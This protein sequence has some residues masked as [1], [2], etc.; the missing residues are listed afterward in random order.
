MEDSPIQSTHSN[1][2]ANPVVEN[3]KISL[4]FQLEQR[5]V[6]KLERE[7]RALLERINNLLSKDDEAR[8]ELLVADKMRRKLVQ[9]RAITE[10]TMKSMESGLN[11]FQ[12]F[13]DDVDETMNDEERRGALRPLKIDTMDDKIPES[14]MVSSST[15][16][17]KLGSILESI[18]KGME[19]EEKE[20]EDDKRVEETVDETLFLDV[21][22][23]SGVANENALKSVEAKQKDEEQQSEKGKQPKNEP[24]S[25]VTLRQRPSAIKLGLKTTKQT[26]VATSASGDRTPA[27]V[28]DSR[29]FSA[30]SSDTSTPLSDSISA[31]AR[32]KR[33]AATKIG[34]YQLPSLSKKMRRDNN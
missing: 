14:P 16:T 6:A 12:T 13:V 18:H 24:R 25:S 33:A 20:K 21:M 10:R 23:T 31:S 4:L 28:D 5:K 27:P 3:T 26:D 15:A 19:E 11:E 2:C 1:F 32:P 22:E 9:L 17:S 8:I 7:N 29:P 34:S 30:A